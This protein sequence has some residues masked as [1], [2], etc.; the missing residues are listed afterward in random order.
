MQF[1]VCNLVYIIWCRYGTPW[2][3]VVISGV[4]TIFLSFLPFASLAEADMLFYNLSNILKFVALVKF[5]F[6]HPD[7][8]RP[9]K[10]RAL[11]HMTSLPPNS[12]GYR[13]PTA[14]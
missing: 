1:G 9:Y 6:S 7:M 11:Q 13:M 10:V 14:Y 3:A 2:V 12:F 4:S 8:P 5:R